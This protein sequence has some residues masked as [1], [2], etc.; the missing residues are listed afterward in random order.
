MSTLTFNI[1]PTDPV[2]LDA[3]QAALDVFRNNGPVK[4]TTKA[5][6]AQKTVAAKADTPAPAV[7]NTAEETGAEEITIEAMRAEIQP[8]AAT[9]RAEIKALITSFGVDKLQ[10]IPPAKRA[11]FIEKAKAL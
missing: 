9:K 2:A 5:P 7:E 6:A 3:A 11:E 4:T 10:N 1:D 8:I